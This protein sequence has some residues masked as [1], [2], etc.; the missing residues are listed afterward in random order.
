MSA[1]IFHLETQTGDIRTEVPVA[2]TSILRNGLVGEF[3]EG[4][5]KIRLMSSS[6]NVTVAR[7]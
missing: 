7:F 1:G 5:P 3:G 4:G 6:G 2:V